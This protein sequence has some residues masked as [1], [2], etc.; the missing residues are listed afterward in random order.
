M[1]HIGSFRDCYVYVI[2]L[3]AGKSSQGASVPITPGSFHLY[4]DSK[5]GVN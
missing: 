1:K 5:Y 2:T 3:E 4:V